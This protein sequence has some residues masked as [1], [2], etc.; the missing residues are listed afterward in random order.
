MTIRRILIFAPLALIAFLLQSYFWVPTYEQQTRGNPDRLHDYI[1]AS[2]G[3]ASLLNPILSA[4]S[5][6]STIESL[7]FEGLIDRDK[8]LRFR[9][10]L[11][12]RWELHE[13]AFFYLNE[14]AALPGRRQADAGSVR[15]LIEAARRR[16][17]ALPPDLAASLNHITAVSVLP[18]TRYRTRLPGKNPATPSPGETVGIEVAAPPRI[19]LVLDRVDQHLFEHLT[20]L[21]GER[22]FCLF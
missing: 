17:A 5:A 6:S 20:E 12:D 11:A 13:E 22:L 10:R 1:T 7:V 21:F 9:G 14:S 19:R 8:D 16:S 18:P 2:I 3:D 15:Q 4:D